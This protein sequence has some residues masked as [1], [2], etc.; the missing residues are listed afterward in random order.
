MH[1]TQILDLD[2]LDTLPHEVTVQD[3]RAALTLPE[4]AWAYLVREYEVGIVSVTAL[5]TPEIYHYPV[6]K[7]N[8]RCGDMAICP[9]LDHVAEVLLTWQA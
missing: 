2:D 1:T 4:G 3:C 5:Q 9:T 7:N 8:W 6:S